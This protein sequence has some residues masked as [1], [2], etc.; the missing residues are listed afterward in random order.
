MDANLADLS[1]SVHDCHHSGHYVPLSLIVLRVN[2]RY[3]HGINA[4]P[5][6]DFEHHM[7]KNYSDSL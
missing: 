2:C 3:F 7:Q 4:T 6:S 5:K 1:P